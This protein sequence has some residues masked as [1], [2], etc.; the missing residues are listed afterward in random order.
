ML[1]P[2]STWMGDHHLLSLT[3][4]AKPARVGS[5]ERVDKI[6]PAHPDATEA[7]P[8]HP[9]GQ[10]YMEDKI[11]PTHPHHNTWVPG[12]GWVASLTPTETKHYARSQPIHPSNVDSL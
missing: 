10:Q 6:L 1:S 3:L 2:V 7:P 4:G 5:N 12:H 8:R 11:L 9:G